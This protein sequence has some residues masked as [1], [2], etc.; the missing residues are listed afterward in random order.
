ML[1]NNSNADLITG[2]SSLLL[3]TDLQQTPHIMV[4][5]LLAVPALGRSGSPSFPSVYCI[6]V[7]LHP[8]MGGSRLCED[9]CPFM[10]TRGAETAVEEP[11]VLPELVHLQLFPD[12]QG[13]GGAGMLCLVLSFY[14]HFLS[15]VKLKEKE[16]LARSFLDMDEVQE[17]RMQFVIKGALR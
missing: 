16:T 4:P 7:I 11:G 14:C 5:I 15:L 1:S 9:V 17:K 2:A 13:P 10:C 3:H 8:C 6:P 12:V